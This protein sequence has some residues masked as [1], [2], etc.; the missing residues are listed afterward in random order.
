MCA[1]TVLTCVCPYGLDA[2]WA[3]HVIELLDMGCCGFVCLPQ[4]QC[5]FQ[6]KAWALAEQVLLEVKISA[7]GDDQL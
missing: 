1:T 5:F 7:G 3:L 6:R 4:P 2:G